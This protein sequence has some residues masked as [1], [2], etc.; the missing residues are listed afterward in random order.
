MWG[1]KSHLALCRDF[2]IEAR[3]GNGPHKTPQTPREP[4]ALGSPEVT[5]D[6]AEGPISSPAR[7]R[8]AILLASNTFGSLTRGGAPFLDE[9]TSKTSIPHPPTQKET[10]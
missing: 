4:S 6:A 9:V 7:A 8:R 1:A 5:G 2:S 10:S 3:W